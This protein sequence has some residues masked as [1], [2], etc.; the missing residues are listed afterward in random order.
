MARLFHREL[1]TIS[2]LDRA[3]QRVDQLRSEPYG[4]LARATTVQLLGQVEE[5]RRG[6]RRSGPGGAELQEGGTVSFRLGDVTASGWTPTAGDGITSVAE[7][8]G[9]SSRAVRWWITEAHR[10]GKRPRSRRADLV[11]C[12]FTTKAPSRSQVGGV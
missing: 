3:G 12:R 10:S 4:Q 9:S 11:V 1:V 7:R 2:P 6:E 8:D 5:D